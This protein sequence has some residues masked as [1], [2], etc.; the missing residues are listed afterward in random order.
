[1]ILIAWVAG[2]AAVLALLWAIWWALF[3]DR[4]RGE[5]RCPRCWHVIDPGVGRVPRLR[6]GECGHWS[7]FEADLHRTRRRW[8]LAAICL[9]ALVGGTLTL[10]LTIVQAGWWTLVPDRALVAISP[11]LG[12]GQD[13]AMVRGW[14]RERLLLGRLSPSSAEALLQRVRDGD[15]T[16]PPGSV[17]WRQRY[18]MWIDALRNPEF[19]RRYRDASGVI[20]AAVSIPPAVEMPLPER[21]R[22][23]TPIFVRTEIEDWLPDGLSL[24]LQV[25]RVEGLPLDADSLDDLRTRRWVRR[26][27]DG[28]S[29]GFP[30]RLG[31]LPAGRHEGRVLWRWSAV[32]A[33]GRTIASGLTASNL[34]VE[35][36]D[37]QPELRAASDEALTGVVR[38]AFRDARMLRSLGGEPSFAFNY[39]PVG[40]QSTGDDPARGVAFGLLVEACENGVP[41][42]SLRLWWCSDTRRLAANEE[43]VEDVAR[44]LQA[45]ESP[46]WTLRIRSDLDLARRAAD[47]RPDRPAS[48]FWEGSIELPLLIEDLPPSRPARPW[49]AERIEASPAEA[50]QATR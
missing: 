2:G 23:G 30:M 18:R 41:R 37:G 32:D 46:E 49:K 6:C 43:P 48:T 39:R 10:R 34:R 45:T 14:L 16:A 15:D 35:V 29:D 17:A 11:W 42:R 44:L 33:R 4:S 21:C 19:W 26:P 24:R 5:R 8:T 22:A 20:D 28:F 1:M 31:A 12:D 38:Q 27:T 47:M 50:P 13:G 7:R 36:L 40:V 9:L 3:A 25:D